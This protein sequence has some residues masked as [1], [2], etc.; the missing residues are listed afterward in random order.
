MFVPL[1]ISA[2]EEEGKKG[3]KCCREEVRVIEENI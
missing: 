1:S 2:V 3:G